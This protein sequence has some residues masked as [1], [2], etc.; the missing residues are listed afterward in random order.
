[1]A[2]TG[3]V[4]QTASYGGLSEEVETDS[5]QFFVVG[6]AERG[7]TDA[8]ILVRGMA[9]VSLYLGNRPT[10]SQVWDQLNT[11]FGEGGRQ[12]WVV[13]VVGPAATKG[14]LT[15][16][17]RASGTPVDTLKVDA[18]NAGAWSS[19]ITIQVR[20]GSVANTFRITV[21]LN[22]VIVEDYTNIATP[23]DAVTK[24]ANSPYVRLTNLGSAT[25]APNNNPAVLA[26]TA[27]TAGV[28]DSGSVTATTYVTALSLFT[29]QLGDGAVAIPG[30]YGDTIW[31][32]L[33]AHAAANNRIALLAATRSETVSNL[34]TTA[35]AKNSEFAGLFAPWVQIS[36]GA[37]G[38]R[39]ISPE[40]FVAGLRAKAHYEV[41]PWRIP[42]G[43]KGI[44]TTIL[45]IDQTFT[46][47]EFDSLD[48]AKVSII[49]KVQNTIRLYGWNSLSA[50]R[51][52]YTFLKDR[53]LL[54]FIVVSSEQ[55]LEE[56][57]F[58]PIDGK[59][60]L[61]GDI[62][63]ALEGLL[64]P[65]ADAGGLF[66]MNGS[67]LEPGIKRDPGYRIDTGPTVNTP[68]T[69]SLNQI[70][71]Q[72]LVRISPAGALIQLTIV[73]VASGISLAEIE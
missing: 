25:V 24:F 14:T 61:L 32:G 54:N 44:A 30:M 1:M 40:G 36:D 73:K 68:A 46:N 38:V 58:A 16:K 12:A 3:I 22:G 45:D 55:I 71:I 31:D 72:M 10:N 69:L 50:D 5:G 42:A 57:L 39:A 52:N 7:R 51:V 21:Y 33:I 8:P 15:L 48:S 47:A 6:L 70:N 66:A 4:V 17:D 65:I 56:Y 26:A 11:F 13:R 53:D 18:A 60:R 27:L 64:V 62:E 19:Q 35:S 67:S 23:T 34:I 63:A 59:G 9:D 29:K 43:A 2:T 41:G 28:D 49:K 20:D 37:G